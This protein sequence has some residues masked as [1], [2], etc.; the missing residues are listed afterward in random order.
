MRSDR[1]LGRPLIGPA[2][3]CGSSSSSGSLA[4]RASSMA[5]SVRAVIL[6]FVPT[7][8][9]ASFTSFTS[10]ASCEANGAGSI[11]TLADCSAAAAALGLSDTTA[12]DDGQNYASGDPPYCY[13]E[14]L[15]QL[16]FNSA[17]TNTGGC[18]SNEHCIWKEFVNCWWST[19]PPYEESP[20]PLWGR[21]A[22]PQEKRNSC[23]RQ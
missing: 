18:Y 21:R 11:T 10:G 17:G 6:A 5:A 19:E 4:A 22:T 8:A 7:C 13:F 3:I 1:S 16:K 2:T 9:A 12:E 23:S 15:T 14:G 20:G